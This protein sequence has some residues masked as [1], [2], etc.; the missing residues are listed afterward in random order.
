MFVID[1][2]HHVGFPGD[3]GQSLGGVGRLDELE[4][5]TT[6]MDRDGVNQAIVIPSH[7]Y[8]RRNGIVDTRLANDN[9]ANYRDTN[10]DRFPAAA[11][12]VEPTHGDAGLDELLRCKEHLDIAAVSIHT[13][14]QGVSLNDPS[15]VAI[16]TRAIELDM[17][18]IIHAYPEDIDEALWKAVQF[19]R[20]MPRV[21]MLILDAF[22]T[23]ESTHY[24]WEAAELCPNFLFD[25]ALSYTFERIQSFVHDFG[26]E[27]VVFGSD[28]YSP[29]PG[30]PTTHLLHHILQSSLS[31]DA[32]ALICGGNAVELFGIHR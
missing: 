2:H 28:T 24:C 29:E 16:V 11:C 5:R 15:V 12:I 18:P 7:A 14:F 17:V 13:R 22:A 20:K 9:I 1:S 10:P 6:V 8:D 30:Q 31:D 21:P 26:P 23:Y 4:G 25:T 3:N 27:R 32:K 19:A